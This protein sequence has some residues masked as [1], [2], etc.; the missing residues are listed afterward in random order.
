MTAV[1]EE[2]PYVFDTGFETPVSGPKIGAN[3]LKLS[4]GDKAAIRLLSEPTKYATHWINA[5]KRSVLC[6]KKA[7]GHCIIC[8]DP[9]IPRD[10]KYASLKFGANVFLHAIQGA[11]DDKYAPINEARLWEGSQAT[12]K[13]LKAAVDE[14][15]GYKDTDFTVQRMGEGTATKYMVMPRKKTLP[16]PDDLEVVDLQAYYTQKM[17]AE[18]GVQPVSGTDG[19]TPDQFTDQ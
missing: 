6:S 15:E 14:A 4:D 10:E 1:I 5:D 18:Q 9:T 3:F 19:D 8:D 17:N 7:T 2:K 12:L 16:V 11:A 13:A